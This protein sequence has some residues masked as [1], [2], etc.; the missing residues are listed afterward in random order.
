VA[1]ELSVFKHVESIFVAYMDLARGSLD[2]KTLANF[3]LP[4][5]NVSAYLVGSGISSAK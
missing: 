4:E 3:L 2:A 1:G 5:V